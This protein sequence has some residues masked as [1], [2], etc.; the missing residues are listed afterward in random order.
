MRHANAPWPE[1]VRDHDRP[2]DELGVRQ[3]KAIGRRLARDGWTPRRIVASTAAR[4]AE[5]ARLVAAA[6][7]SPMDMDPSLYGAPGSHVLEA[8]MDGEDTMLVAHNPA[9]EEAIRMLAAD[10]LLDGC[11][12]GTCA[13]FERE[14]GDAARLVALLR[15]GDD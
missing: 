5:T 13:V 10:A 7:G 14:S 12:P 3:A 6:T 11:P 8:A 2:L 4:A 1:G 9:I 15:P